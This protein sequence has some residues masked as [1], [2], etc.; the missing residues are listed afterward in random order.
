MNQARHQEKYALFFTLESENGEIYLLYIKSGSYTTQQGR[1]LGN[2][3]NACTTWK[4]ISLA[5]NYALTGLQIM[6]LVARHLWEDIEILT[7]LKR[8][9]EIRQM[10]EEYRTLLSLL[11][12]HRCAKASDPR[13]KLYALVSLANDLH[14]YPTLVPDY[15]I[16]TVSIPFLSPKQ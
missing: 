9:I 2:N 3:W 5:L 10:Q 16:D 13:D 7:P 4:T 6:D 1:N 11:I 15:N 8:L 14:R 12:S